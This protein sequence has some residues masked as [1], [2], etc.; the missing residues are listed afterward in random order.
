MFSEFRYRTRWFTPSSAL[1]ML[2]LALFLGSGCDD[3]DEDG[4]G[5]TGPFALTFQLDASFQGPHGG[6][7]IG[8]A[9]VRVS[10]GSVVARGGGTVSDSQDPAFSFSAPDLLQ[11]GTAYE[12]RY[13]IDS[14]F[15][16]GALGACDVTANDHQWSVSVPAPSA[17]VMITEMHDAANVTSVCNSFSLDFNF[18]LDASF[19]TPHG[20]QDIYVAVVRASDGVVA[21]RGSGTV[22]ATQDPAFS[23]DFTILASGLAVGGD[24]EVHYWID[25]NFGGGNIGVCDAAA[26]DHQWSVAGTADSDDVTVTEAHVPANVTDVCGTF[27]ANLN[28]GGDAS[29]QAPH[30]D[31]DISVSLVRAADGAVIA[32][33]TGTVS[34]TADP[35]FS[36]AFPGA[37]VI[38]VEYNVEY[39]IDSNF[40]GGT[41][42][43]C[44][45]PDIDHQWRVNVPSVA[46]D[47]DI[48]ETHDAGAITDVCGT[49]APV[50]F[51][52]DIQPI[53]TGN[54]AFSGCHG[55]T[56][57]QPIGKP[58]EL[59][60]GQAYDNIVNVSSF[61][62]PSMD[63]IEPGQPDNSY[64][65]HKIQGSHL[66]VGGSGSRMPLGRDPLTQDVINLV[67]RWVSEGAAN[68]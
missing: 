61:E 58:Q 64:L 29:F 51:A 9:V 36:F 59:A 67:R 1:L 60:A 2:A 21:A 26:T 11:S 40:G 57:T 62:L 25:S 37:L 31:Q 4:T 30:G 18:S 52:N 49:A 20:G 22:S 56:D 42:G 47:V 41:V 63:R 68:N 54:C 3:D 39:W 12:V 44:D 48:T 8:L 65:V 33:Q 53:F 45:A 50:S 23:F 34:G 10:D 5:P 43:E 19:Q 7:P 46:A 32:T 66:D 28:F 27:A 38:G 13:W 14:N 6:Q 17:D 35:S 24:Y 15:G 16:G 55:T